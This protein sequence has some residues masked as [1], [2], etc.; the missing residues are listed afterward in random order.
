MLESKD[1]GIKLFGR[2]IPLSTAGAAADDLPLSS[3]VDYADEQG[4]QEDDDNGEE[5][6]KVG[7]KFQGRISLCD[8]GKRPLP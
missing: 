1:P 2:Q 7:L 6:E 5:T 3:E 4:E 8:S